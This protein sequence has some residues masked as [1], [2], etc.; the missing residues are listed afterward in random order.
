[1]N[2]ILS[3]VWL[4]LLGQML[5]L[6]AAYLI[7]GL[8]YDTTMTLDKYSKVWFH[9]VRVVGCV[10]IGQ[11]EHLHLPCNKEQLEKKTLKS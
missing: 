1:M 9:T 8:H 2:I 4:L 3:P 6:I 7:I 5:F 11:E 10:R